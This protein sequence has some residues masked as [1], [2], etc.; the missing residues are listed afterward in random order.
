MMKPILDLLLCASLLCA[1]PAHAENSVP[2]PAAAST[3]A[4]PLPLPVARFPTT[5]VK[6]ANGKKWRMAYFRSGEYKNYPLNIKATIQG[7]ETLGWLKLT[8][9]I[10]ENLAGKAL[11]QFMAQ[12][13]ASDYLELVEDA[14]WEPGD[15]N[16]A[17]RSKVRAEIHQRLSTKHDIDLIIAMGTWAGQ[18]MVELGVPVPTV[19]LSASDPVNSGIIKSPRDSGHDNLNARI[20]PE[21]NREQVRLFHDIIP[22]TRLGLIYED[23]PEGHTYSAIDDV[24]AVGQ[25]LGFEVLT[26]EAPFAGDVTDETEKKALACYA[27]LAQEADAIYVTEHRAIR[28]SAIA[29]VA[30]ILRRAKIP[31][32]SM[33]G[34]EEVKAGILMS[35]AQADFSYIG[36]FHAETIARIFNGAQPRQLTQIW[37]DPAKIVLNLKT[38]RLIGFDPPVD[39]LLAADEVFEAR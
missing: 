16:A 25:Q 28:E 27:K 9:S 17:L 21:R 33:Q 37:A 34:S 11:W 29:K 12:H 18:D 22:F 39:I 19:V 13:T 6:K 1:L 15:F 31:S 35:M 30:A 20:Y 32:F 3:T 14:F 10:P 5:P 24:R 23:T 36:M 8:A 4:A 7:L 2:L 26:C 38:T